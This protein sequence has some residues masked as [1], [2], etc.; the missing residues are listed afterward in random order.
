MNPEEESRHR[1]Q[2]RSSK[3]SSLGGFLAGLLFCGL[4]L[5][6]FSFFLKKGGYSL[7]KPQR[8]DIETA[9]SPESP[10]PPSHSPSPESPPSGS[11]EKAHSVS[12]PVTPI[13]VSPTKPYGE[14]IT[15]MRTLSKEFDYTSTVDVK[16]GELAS[17]ERKE[18]DSYHAHYTLTI[19]EP[20]P[21]LTFEDV[22]AASPSLSSQLPALPLLLETAAVHPY[23]RQLYGLKKKRTADNAHHLLKLL[24]KHNFYDCQTILS[25]RHP[26]TGRAAVLLQGDMDVV[27]DGSDGDR[28]PTMPEEIITSTHY[29]PTTSY[30]WKKQTDSPNPLIAGH[31]KRIQNADAE[32][33]KPGTS[34]DRKNWLRDRKKKLLGTIKEME[35]RSFLIAEYDPF[36]VLPVPVIV[37]KDAYSPNV[38][39]YAIVFHG[40]NMYPAIVGDAGPDYKVGEASLRIAKE[41]N[42]KASP[43]YRP[44]SDLSVS[45]LIFPGTRK[46]PH[47]APDYEDIR[48]ECLRL[49]EELGGLGN[50]ESLHAWKDLFP[51]P[52]PEGEV[53]EASD[54]LPDVALPPEISE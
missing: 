40:E 6:V 33:A 21:A 29:Q 24:T 50:A 47:R 36:I 30:S 17:V 12:Q 54:P 53:G 9:S 41:I 1:P 31:R 38:G 42:S 37:A 2:K 26:E 14:K 51:K 15:A 34:A 44:V 27:A 46:E 4:L 20:K 19:H 7:S 52:E 49:A 3:G 48:S 35:T 11:P 13:Q 25:L 43:Y 8:G 39:D 45:Y 18:S 22:T 16:P 10:P 23:W 32:I 5:A 28:L